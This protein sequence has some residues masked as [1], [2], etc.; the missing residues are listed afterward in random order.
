MKKSLILA[1]ALIGL[2]LLSVAPVYGF[3]HPGPTPSDDELSERWGP[4]V[5]T[6]EI[7]IYGSQEAEY[8]AFFAQEID[9]MDW[10]LLP[11][12]LD[13]L[14]SADPNMET[15]ARA[16]YVEFGLFEIDINNQ[17]FPTD[18]VNFRRAL[19]YLIDKAYFINYQLAGLGHVANSPLAHNPGWY[20]PD[21]DE[22]Y[23]YDPETAA[24]ILEA[25][26]YTDKDDDG[27]IEG[28]NGEEIVL[29]FYG[30]AD[31]PN[32]SELAN[33]F[34]TQLEQTLKDTS[35]GA[36]ID[37]DLR[38]VPK[39][40]CFQKVMAEYD[41]HLYTGGWSFGRDPTTIYFLYHSSMCFKPEPYS[42][43]YP[44]YS[45]PE[46][47][48]AV[49]GMLYAST[50]EEAKQYCMEAQ[51]I[52][53]QDAG[54]IPVWNTAGYGAYL[55]KWQNVIC[56]AYGTWNWNTWLNTYNPEVGQQGGT[57]K[58]GFMNDIEALN[59]VHSEWVWDWYVLDKI[60]EG[61]IYV[62][63]YDFSKDE[64]WIAQSWE[65]G[66]WTYE[67]EPATWV[68]F[69]LRND[70][71][72]QDV[73]PKADRVAPD[74]TPILPDGATDVLLTA[75]DVKFT[76]EYIRSI[77]D[78]WNNDLVS[79]V[80]YCE[81][82]DPFTITVYYG[83][84][85]P[86]WAMHWAAGLPV[87]PKHIWEKVPG[88][89]AREFDPITQ[90]AL[91]GSGPFEFVLYDKEAGVIQLNKYTRYFMASPLDAVISVEGKAHAPIAPDTSLTYNVTIY[92][93]DVDDDITADITILLDG[94]P[95]QTYT[96]VTIPAGGKVE[97]T[98]LS[99]GA[100]SGG[101]HKIEVTCDITAPDWA[102]DKD[103]WTQYE[104]WFT[105]PEDLNLDFL[106]DIRDISAAG[107]A[108]A[109]FPGHPR[110]DPKA[111]LNDDFLVD[112]RDISAIGRKFGWHT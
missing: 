11:S 18:D 66:E 36:G 96:G 78:A 25:N 35:L 94:T 3:F 109:S 21:C 51:L 24:A 46:Y 23:T 88:D 7:H 32:R 85:M 41:Y 83:V 92:N 101:Y 64:P 62:D 60:Y 61:L 54:I 108:F 53:M 44:C 37:V 65:I 63:P 42:P 59:V 40:E 12:Q 105:I 77:P 8:E 98:D 58:W 87:M 103:E 95:V 93:N 15:Y 57:V 112:I 26:G 16:F 76:I 86:L 28:P 29:V 38:I 72:W 100:L 5:D 10:P 75:E 74:G 13:E 110:W 17:R 68:K 69:H 27:W 14:E 50:V 34:T 48:E 55:S 99:T 4:R 33:Y 31:D 9:F 81:V 6:I 82:N 47:D 70:V 1:V 104:L 49:E 90:D 20:N 111:D 107:R 97:Y 84:Y 52:L 22:L 56:N 39:S 91:Q 89:M 67:G 102:A 43:N 71:Y 30:R 80:V 2:M 79:D 45:N 19:S 73:P 106:V